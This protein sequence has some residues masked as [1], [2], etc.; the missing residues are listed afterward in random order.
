MIVNI[1]EVKNEQ[2]I[3]DDCMSFLA[4]KYDKK[5]RGIGFWKKSVWETRFFT[6]F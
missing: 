1:I 5:N 4:E 2:K 3:Y 6:A